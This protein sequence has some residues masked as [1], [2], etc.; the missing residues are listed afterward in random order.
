MT[1]GERDSAIQAAA[2]TANKLA[3]QAPLQLTFALGLLFMV[4]IQAY[5]DYKQEQ[6]VHASFELILDRCL[7]DA[8]GVM[9]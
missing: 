7:V 9:Q 5:V 6:D 8:D 1:D 2:Q 3:A 4:G